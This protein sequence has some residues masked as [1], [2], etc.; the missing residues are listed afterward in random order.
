MTESLEESREKVENSK[1]NT[2]THPEPKSEPE[3]YKETTP[4]PKPKS[5]YESTKEKIG[6][7]VSKTKERVSDA[8]HYISSTAS[9]AKTIFRAPE[10][11]SSYK[12]IRSQQAQRI[13]TERQEKLKAVE[14]TIK[15]EAKARY[16]ESKKAIT[17]IGTDIHK[18]GEKTGKY[19]KGTSAYRGAQLG[20]QETKEKFKT[21]VREGAYATGKEIGKSPLTLAKYGVKK[22]REFQTNVRTASQKGWHAGMLQ[23][24]PPR[25]QGGKYLGSGRYL[26][27]TIAF[28]PHD[29]VGRQPRIKIPAGLIKPY[30]SK[31]LKK[32]ARSNIHR[33][34]VEDG[35]SRTRQVAEL[36]G[37]K[38]Q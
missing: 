37:W 1:E 21:G 17:S 30:W 8:A 31:K 9:R 7:I 20:F 18:A 22:A 3:P 34:G 29:T 23:R 28:H 6:H 2:P 24:A 35:M 4:E 36:S 32:L 19:V 38:W 15:A 11:P 13:A 12:P 25:I 27:K 16:T 5:T 14:A 33:F 10:K 26:G